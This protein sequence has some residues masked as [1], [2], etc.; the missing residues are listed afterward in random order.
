MSLPF[1]SN[2]CRSRSA[3]KH[4]AANIL[5]YSDE[6]TRWSLPSFGPSS[7]PAA[8]NVIALKR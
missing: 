7:Q 6:I 2:S 4:Y 1:G 5:D 8:G 3:T